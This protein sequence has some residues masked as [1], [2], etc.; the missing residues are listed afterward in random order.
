MI[1]EISKPNGYLLDS[2]GNVVVRFGNWEVGE[3][4]VPDTVES[5]EY[6][7]GPNTHNKPVADQY[8]PNQ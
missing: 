2:D 4:T 3:H 6:V 7:D 5:V 8:G 1:I